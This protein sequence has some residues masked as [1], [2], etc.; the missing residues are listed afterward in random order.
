MKNCVESLFT[1]YHDMKRNRASQ[2]KNVGAYKAFLLYTNVEDKIESRN[3]VRH[4]YL[5]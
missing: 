4:Y 5:I 3:E 2:Q 1:D